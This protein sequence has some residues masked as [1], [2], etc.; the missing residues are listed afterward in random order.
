MAARRLLEL[1]DLLLVELAELHRR[2]LLNETLAVV[3]RYL[4]RAAVRLDLAVRRVER[5]GSGDE[6][7]FSFCGGD[8]AALGLVGD[9][10]VERGLLPRAP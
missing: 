10:G 8:L 7:D 6:A 4:D 2:V 1:A 5:V 3:G 9:E